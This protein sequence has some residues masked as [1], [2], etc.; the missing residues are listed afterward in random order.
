LLLSK[1]AK[2]APYEH[3]GGP[4]T[5]PTPADYD[6][7]THSGSIVSKQAGGTAQ[8]APIHA[9]LNLL[10]QREGLFPLVP[11]LPQ[12]PLLLRAEARPL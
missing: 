9:H 12:P 2:L 6:T 11:Q 8:Q 4:P 5:P 10:P 7:Y 1:K 3:Q